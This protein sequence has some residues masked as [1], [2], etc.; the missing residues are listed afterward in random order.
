VRR[1]CQR[2]NSVPNSQGPLELCVLLQPK[3]N[4]DYQKIPKSEE[5][6]ALAQEFKRVYWRESKRKY[7]SQLSKQE[8][9]DAVNVSTLFQ[10]AKARMSFAYFCK[11]KIT[12]VLK[13]WNAYLI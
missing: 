5:E 3:T 2:I 9:E 4:L 11:Q 10:I 8:R 1:R 12:L 7:R 6:G 13:C